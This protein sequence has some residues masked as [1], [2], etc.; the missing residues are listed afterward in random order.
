M[1]IRFAI[2]LLPFFAAIGSAQT[3][4]ALDRILSRLQQMEKDNQKLAEEVRALR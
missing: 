4:P 2:A 1:T 3:E